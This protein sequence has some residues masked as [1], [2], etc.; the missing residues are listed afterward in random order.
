MLSLTNQGALLVT[1]DVALSHK[2]P[3]LLGSHL[4]DTFYMKLEIYVQ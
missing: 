1:H 3:K 2:H 4:K